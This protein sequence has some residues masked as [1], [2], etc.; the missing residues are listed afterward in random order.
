[1]GVEARA[2]ISNLTHKV[3]ALSLI[4]GEGIYAHRE[5]IFPNQRRRPLGIELEAALD[6]LCRAHRLG[7][8]GVNSQSRQRGGEELLARAVG[9]L[10]FCGHDDKSMDACDRRGGST[11][12][13]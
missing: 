6:G 8:A 11:R 13:R 7:L 9:R 2:I 4:A 3:V 1:M 5:S 12:R 10:R